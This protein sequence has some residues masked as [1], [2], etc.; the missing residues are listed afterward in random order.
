MTLEALEANAE[1]PP[2]AVLLGTAPAAPGG[3][4]MAVGNP[5]RALMI[6]RLDEWHQAF[7]PR[8]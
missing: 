1:E 4:A 6:T 5:T 8:Q 7:P 3:A 2:S